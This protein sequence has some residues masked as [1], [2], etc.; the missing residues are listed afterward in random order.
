MFIVQKFY[1]S[2]GNGGINKFFK[3]I[4]LNWN[5]ISKIAIKTKTKKV[6]DLTNTKV[7]ELTHNLT[8]N[9][10]RAW[11]TKIEIET[12]GIN[13]FILEVLGLCLIGCCFWLQKYQISYQT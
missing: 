2:I 1:Q 12:N 3:I 7:H 6:K 11:G 5:E 10:W 13:I 4:T 8:Y 9:K